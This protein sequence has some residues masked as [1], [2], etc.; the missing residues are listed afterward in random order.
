MP[1]YGTRYQKQSIMQSLDNLKSETRMHIYSCL[2]QSSN[3]S[4]CLRT[5]NDFKKNGYMFKLTKELSPI[6]NY[7]IQCNILFYTGE[8]VIPQKRI[9]EN[10]IGELLELPAI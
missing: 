6:M 10:V 3:F 5:L 4:E 9:I 8:K 1:D 2:H 7:L